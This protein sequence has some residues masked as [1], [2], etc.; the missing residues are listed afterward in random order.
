VGHEGVA[1]SLHRLR[2]DFHVLGTRAL[3]AEFV[4]AC[5]TCQRNKAKQLHP[6]DL[7]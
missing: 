5:E 4:R 6:A 3:V 7:L 1:N 2:V